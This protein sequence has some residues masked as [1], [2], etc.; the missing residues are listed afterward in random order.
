MVASLTKIQQAI[1]YKAGHCFK[2][3]LVMISGDLRSHCPRVKADS[4]DM[5]AL[6]LGKLG[7]LLCMVDLGQL[8][9]PIQTVEG[10]HATIGPLS[11][12]KIEIIN[13]QAFPHCKLMT[14]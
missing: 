13:V 2:E 8:A 10:K 4:H 12:A 1:L 14:F 9:L 5:L 3:S 6:F 11:K 7:H